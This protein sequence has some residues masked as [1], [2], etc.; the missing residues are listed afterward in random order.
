MKRLPA[1]EVPSDEAIPDSWS[2]I[3]P[4]ELASDHPH[5]IAI[6]PFGSNLLKSDY[7]DSGVRLIFVRN[8]RAADFSDLGSRFVSEKKAS[9]LRSHSADAGDLLVTKMGDPPG[10]TAIYPEGL[11]PAIITSDCI[12][13]TPHPGLT[14]SEFLSAAIR[15]QPVK[16]QILAI[17]T[18]VAHQKVSLDRF[19][20]IAIPIPPLPEQRRIVAK[21]DRLS[22]RSAAA[23]DHLARTTKFAARAKQAILDWETVAGLSSCQTQSIAD[24]AAT[25]FD[26]PFGSNLKTEDY[27]AFGVRVVRLENIGVMS[28]RA[29][30]ETFIAVEKFATL[31]RHELFADDVVFS[32]FVADDIRATLIPGDL[33]PAINKADCFCIRADRSVICPKF[34]LYRLSARQTFWDM[35]Q[36]VHGA[37]RPRIGLNHLKTYR[38]AVPSIAEQQAIVRRIE[39]AF[40]RIDRLTEEATRAAHLLDRF[41]ERLLAKA[42]RG[43]LVPQNP[44][45][46]PAEVLLARIRAARAGAPTARHK[47]RSAAE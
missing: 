35:E 45:D 37:T 20:K 19:R 43:D 9:E 44:D 32:S 36:L 18:G 6:G 12:K 16:N 1:T 27:T 38:V 30:K 23:R 7:Q 25:L 39:A 24:V 34:L 28:F 47:K 33:G 8:I 29:D 15:S 21:L 10:D 31:R 3:S 46:E 14:S 42:F 17:T 41:D 11:G 2:W 26:G 4:D 40:A 22:A 13:I 5:S